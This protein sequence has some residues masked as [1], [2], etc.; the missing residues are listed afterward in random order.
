MTSDN[1][2]LHLSLTVPRA[3]LA[4]AAELIATGLHTAA[5]LIPGL[6]A[7][8]ASIYEEDEPTEEEADEPNLGVHIAG[9]GGL[10]VAGVMARAN[11]CAE[12][13]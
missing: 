6:V 10:D 5:L 13:S 3:S 7:S 9:T 1:V 11:H 4:Q 12:D 8:S 2:N